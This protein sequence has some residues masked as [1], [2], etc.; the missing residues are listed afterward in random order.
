MS[1]NFQVLEKAA[2]ATPL[3]P[4]PAYLPAVTSERTGEY[5]E[6]IRRLFRA[7]SAVAVIGRRL[8]HGLTGIC[9]GIAIELA[10]CGK[11][12]VIVPVAA[13][14]RMNPL[15]SPDQAQL[16]PL[17][18]QN[19]WLWPSAVDRNI[20]FFKPSEPVKPE[21]WLDGLRRNFDSVL[22]D[23]PPLSAAAG[24]A[25]VAAMADSVILVVE[26]GRTSKKE[27]QRD[28][29]TLQMRGARLAG[30]ILIQRR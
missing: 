18:G 8:D 13:L 11:R 15:P 5:S 22:L 23:C 2:L 12:V 10:A 21:N 14:L 27:I 24:A 17:Q 9:Q 29:R 25:E 3:D 7:Q 16:S 19:V 26:A 20:E 1:R 4:H 6:L 30:S 28:Q